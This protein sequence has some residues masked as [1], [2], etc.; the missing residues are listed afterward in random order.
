M[1]SWHFHT[2]DNKTYCDPDISRSPERADYREYTGGIFL[3]RQ[4]WSSFSTNIS[5]G[6]ASRGN[7]DRHGLSL[8]DRRRAAGT[9][10]LANFGGL[11]LA[12]MRGSMLC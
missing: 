11:V 10:G 6:T 2:A 8:Y 9:T 5:S 7:S 3:N 4:A 12:A 1:T